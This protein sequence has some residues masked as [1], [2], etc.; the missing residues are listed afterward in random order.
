MQFGCKAPA[1]NLQNGLI[2][3]LDNTKIF[4]MTKLII[5]LII[6]LFLSKGLIAQ[7][8]N[9]SAD[10]IKTLLCHKWNFRAI[11][12]GGQ[13]MTNFNETVIYEFS[14]DFTLQRVTEKKTE[15]GVW[16]YDPNKLLILIKIKKTVLFVQKLKEGDLVVSVGDGTDPKKNSLGVATA[17][18]LT[19]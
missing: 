15:K 9:V 16:S 8:E 2:P 19:N 13:E 3:I 12:M 7:V 5:F 14:N 4:N 11:I 6:P 1:K 17:L 18:K 10:S